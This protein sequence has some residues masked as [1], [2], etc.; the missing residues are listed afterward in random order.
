MR[1]NKK[2]TG[3][4]IHCGDQFIY[5]PQQHKGKYCSNACRGN[6][7]ICEGF[8]EGSF[9][10]SNRRRYFREQLSEP[11]CTICG[12]GDTWNGSPLTLQIDHINGNTS[13]NR[14]TNL[15]MLCPNCHTQT[16]TWGNPNKKPNNNF[17]GM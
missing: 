11:K 16:D 13:D 3:T 17:K 6:H 4:C 12:Q 8:K 2:Q 15:R 1:S 14:L 5:W 10:T 7:Q 9:L